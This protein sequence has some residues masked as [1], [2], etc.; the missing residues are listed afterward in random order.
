MVRAPIIFSANVSHC[1]VNPARRLIRSSVR[2]A[3]PNTD[4]SVV[5]GKLGVQAGQVRP[6]VRSLPVHIHRR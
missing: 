6:A 2:L 3:G 5:R 1:A 4:G